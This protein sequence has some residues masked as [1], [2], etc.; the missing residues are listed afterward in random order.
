MGRIMEFT[1]LLNSSD[2]VDRERIDKALLGRKIKSIRMM[3][4]QEIQRMGWMDPAVVL[5]LDNGTELYSTTDVEGNDHGILCYNI[6]TTNF[7]IG[8]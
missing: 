7:M 5:T 2:P 6:K 3:T 8:G 4:E 1:T